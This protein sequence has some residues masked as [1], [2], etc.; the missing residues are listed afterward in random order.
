M[1][2]DCWVVII[3]PKK[4]DNEIVLH[5]L[6]WDQAKV[7]LNLADALDVYRLSA[8]QEMY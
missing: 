1:K 7:C 4:D 2:N 8:Y 3:T 5:D 6:T